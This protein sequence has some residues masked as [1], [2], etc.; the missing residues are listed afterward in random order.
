MVLGRG[1]ARLLPLDQSIVLDGAWRVLCGQVPFADFTMAFGLAGMWLQAAVFGICGV[2]FSSF[3]LTAATLNAAAAVMAVLVVR[4]VLP[5]ATAAAWTAGVLTAIW[6]HPPFGTPYAE[7]TA[8]FFCMLGLLLALGVSRGA[9]RAAAWRAAAA[10]ACMVAAF[11]AKQ[12]AG[13]LFAPVIAVVLAIDGARPRDWIACGGG[14]AAAGSVFTGWLLS[15]SNPR[16]FMR[17]WFEIPGEMVLPRFR[18]SFPENLTWISSAR[19]T[20]WP[21]PR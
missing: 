19:G 14:I 20:W 17:F 21:A 5:G 6:Y 16:T 7:Q 13:L 3:L 8:F 9:R 10:G 2:S 1:A 12:N 15:A 18:E 4:R 11:L